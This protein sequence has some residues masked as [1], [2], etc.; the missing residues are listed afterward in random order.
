MSINLTDE[1]LAKSKKGKIASAKQVFLEG[2]QEN[3][4]Q[5]GEKTHQLEDAFKDITITGGASTANV[6]SYNN[7]TSGMTAVTA[8]GAIDELAAKNTSQD[9]EISKKANSEDITSQMQTE[10]TRVNNELAKKF[11]SENITQE[12]GDSTNKVMSQKAV[13]TKLSDLSDDFN[14]LDGSIPLNSKYIE[15][16]IGDTTGGLAGQDNIDAPKRFRSKDVLEISEKPTASIKREGFETAGVIFRFY[17][18]D[19][20]YIGTSYTDEAK[21]LRIILSGVNG[22]NNVNYT[23]LYDCVLILNNTQYSCTK[24]KKCASKD[25]T[26]NTINNGIVDIKKSISTID[27][28]VSLRPSNVTEFINFIVDGKNVSVSLNASYIL[29]RNFNYQIHSSLT[30]SINEYGDYCVIYNK[31]TDSLNIVGYN[32][33][34]NEYNIVIIARFFN[35]DYGFKLLY[36][37]STYYKI[38]GISYNLLDCVD[39]LSEQI[40]NQKAVSTKLNGLS[41]NFNILDGSIPLNSKYIEFE[42]GDTTGG[43]AGQDNIDAPKRFRSKDVLEISEKPT[44]SIKREGFE[45]AGV[46]FR[47]YKEDGVYIGTSYT[48]EAK[49][50]RIILSGVNGD[51]NVN[52]TNL[53]D[54]VL[55]LN[56]TQYSCTKYKKCASKDETNANITWAELGDSFVAPDNNNGNGYGKIIRRKIDIPESN[57]HVAG[58]HGY[59]WITFYKYAILSNDNK[60]KSITK[61]EDFITIGLGTNDWGANELYPIGTKED[62]I[63]NTFNNSDYS[64]YTSYGAARKVIDWLLENRGKNTPNV[65][66]LAPM[67]RGQLGSGSSYRPSDYIIEDGV[68]KYIENTEWLNKNLSSKGLQTVEKGFT[69]LDVYEMVK[70][71]AEYEGFTFVDFFNNGFVKTRFLNLGKEETQETSKVYTDQLSDNLH[72]YTEKG[73]NAYASMVYQYGF[74]P[75][76]KL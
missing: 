26:E 30:N 31:N 25:E 20:V 41:E 10:Q 76:L 62:Y 46:I 44:A 37:C 7:E 15:F 68:K 56:N 48:D 53:Y 28:S 39:K 50:L 35:Q 42:I 72:P 61:D 13:S 34:P 29:G 70:W 38:N 5:I 73:K 19:G 12:S 52:Y 14:I 47:F 2:D 75:L 66:L 54:C 27:N 69:L 11:N 9:A 43:L 45:T 40:E 64:T 6:V 63:N 36:V 71:I 33:I 32:Q 60:L 21:K 24:Y 58:F 17:K 4:Q 49:K 18:E 3:L 22:D 8:Q 23:N 65:I 74:V 51:N 57:H 1:L 55:I 16:E 59:S 67:H